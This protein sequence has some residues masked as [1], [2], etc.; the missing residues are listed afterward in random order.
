MPHK[1]ERLQARHGTS[2]AGYPWQRFAALF[3][4]PCFARGQASVIVKAE[5]HTIGGFLS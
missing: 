3:Q 4:S 5:A 1:A 2:K